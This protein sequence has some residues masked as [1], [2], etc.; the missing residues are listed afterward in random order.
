MT[1]HLATDAPTAHPDHTTVT[2]A[3]FAA[4]IDALESAAPATAAHLTAALAHARRTGEPLP[5]ATARRLGDAIHDTLAGDTPADLLDA[6]RTCRTC[7]GAGSVRPL[8]LRRRCDT[9][10]GVGATAILTRDVVTRVA[11]VLRADGAVT[12]G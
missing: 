7:H 3:Q 11:A 8:L 4:L 1:V 2:L 5:S 12:V 9:C 10:D 6:H